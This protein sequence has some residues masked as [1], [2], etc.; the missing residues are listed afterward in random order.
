AARA[1]PPREGRGGAAAQPS[2]AGGVTASAARELPLP[3][4]RSLPFVEALY[5]TFRRDPS[6]VAPSWR[7]YFERLRPDGADR[8]ATPAGTE[9]LALPDAAA[10]QARVDA[11][12]QA[13]RDRGHLAAAIDP[14]GGPA[15]G[16]PALALA[17]HGLTA[18]D[19]ERPCI[20]PW[21]GTGPPVRLREVVD[22]LTA[23]YCGTL[24][25]ESAHIDDEA[26]RRWIREA[27]EGAGAAPPL[28]PAARARAL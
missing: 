20:S 5:E 24:G 23:A 15:P 14:L 27:V 9:R 26:R 25:V 4:P 13:Y 21:D 10:F 3:D 28:D 12:V 16:H 17:Y 8:A 19:L 22:R 6:A 2:A 7:A 18:A 11:L 1:A